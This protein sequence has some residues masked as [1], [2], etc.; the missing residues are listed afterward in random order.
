MRILQVCKKFPWPLKDGESIAIFQLTEAF[1]QAGHELTVLAMNTPKHRFDAGFLPQRVKDSA[2]FFAIDVDTS[3][4]PFAALL[5]LIT[6]NSYNLERF[7][8][9]N[10]RDGLYE[11]LRRESYDLVQLEGLYLAPYLNVIRSA[12][13]APVVLRAHNVEFEIWEKLARGTENSLKRWYINLLARR[14]KNFEIK[15]LQAFDALVPISPVDEKRFRELGAS[16]AIHTCTA[17]ISL[18]GLH[19]SSR[20]SE[21]FALGYLGALDWLPNRE[22]LEWFLERSWPGV[23]EAFPQ[24]RFRI[25]G[26]NAPPKWPSKA[27]PGV[28][29][30]GEV[31][32]ARTF[33]QDQHIV[34]MPLLSGSGM[35]I[36]LLEALA[37]GKAVVATP[38]AAEGVL[39]EEG[40]HAL[41]AAEPDAFTGAIVRFLREP[42]LAE[43]CGREG[44]RLI[45]QQYD[46]EKLVYELL[47]FY[48]HL[49]AP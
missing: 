12:T 26:R 2:R 6:R 33:L 22:G 37:L 42:A 32:D 46:R 4:K 31:E 13:R 35:R 18:D 10:F 23:L 21:P 15:A 49:L 11:L 40:R 19:A 5:N 20:D 25:A 9:Q 44:Q 28:E 34:V 41:L 38:Q 47:D 43:S 7:Y 48:H 45:R 29:I 16:G 17:G 1:A 36:K 39:V 27:Y 24:A 14:L 8:H 30:I 3:V